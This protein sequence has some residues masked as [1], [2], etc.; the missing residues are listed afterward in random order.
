MV[1]LSCAALRALVETWPGSHLPAAAVASSSETYLIVY[2]PT[3]PPASSRA[4][5]S[6]L[7][8]DSDC[9]RESPCNGRLE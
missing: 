3:L 4:S 1:D 7:T 6:P 5:F 9:G 8:T 2:L